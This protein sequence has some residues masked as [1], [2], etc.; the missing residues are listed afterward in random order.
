MDGSPK[1]G[2]SNAASSPKELLLMALGGCTASDVTSILRKKRSPVESLEIR[3]AG[4]VFNPDSPK[5]NRPQG[6]KRRGEW[7]IYAEELRHGWM[8]EW[9]M[10]S[11]QINYYGAFDC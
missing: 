10:Q 5:Q 8:L 2:G 1:F 9:D 4:E 11:N 3:L 6:A 7:L